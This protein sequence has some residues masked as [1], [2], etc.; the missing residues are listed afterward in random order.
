MLAAGI[1]SLDFF[2][3]FL[4][5]TVEMLF[6]A[7][8][9]HSDWPLKVLNR[10]GEMFRQEGSQLTSKVQLDQLVQRTN[11]TDNSFA[12]SSNCV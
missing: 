11:M 8:H 7:M 10:P 9:T 2:S 5:Q 4:Q 3:L 12:A 1:C 6:L